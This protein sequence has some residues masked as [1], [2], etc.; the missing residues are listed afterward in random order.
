[1]SQNHHVLCC[2]PTINNLI[3]TICPKLK[4]LTL[5]V[6]EVKDLLDEQREKNVRKENISSLM[7]I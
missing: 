6:S 2:S 5:D 3:Q 7:Y 4:V 1:M